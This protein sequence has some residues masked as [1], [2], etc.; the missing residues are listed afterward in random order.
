MNQKFTINSLEELH[1][2]CLA[3]K[4]KKYPHTFVLQG[5]LGAG[6]TTLVRT[7]ISSWDPEVIVSSPTFTLMNVYHCDGEIIHHFDLYRLSNTYEAL[8]WGFEEF[9]SQCDYAFIEWAERAWELIPRPYTLIQIN[10]GEH[11]SQRE[12]SISVQ[13]D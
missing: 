5:D 7:F 10:Y 12:I 1:K 2:V 13:N 8:E 4:H 3:L 11:E 9:V 6:K